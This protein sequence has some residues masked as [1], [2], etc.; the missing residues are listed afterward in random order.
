MSAKRTIF[1]VLVSLGLAAGCHSK[2]SAPAPT[3][4]TSS[5]PNA[6][7]APVVLPKVEP[8]PLPAPTPPP[9]PSP[10]TQATAPKVS[11]N[12]LDGLFGPALSLDPKHSPNQ[13]EGD[14]NGDGNADAIFLVMVNGKKDAIGSDVKAANIFAYEKGS[15]WK[16]ASPD[17]KS[18]RAIALVLGGTGGW[19][20]SPTAKYLLIDV[21]REGSVLQTPLWDNPNTSEFITLF[22]KGDKKKKDYPSYVPASAKGDVLSIATEAADMIIYY[23]GAHFVRKESPQD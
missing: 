3:P 4:P 8:K 12:P 20:Q 21:D 9:P 5:L 19:K 13:W 6:A 14:L 23:D 18:R 1:A 10:E 2:E 17:I 16:D 11:G 22:H 15:D 7:T